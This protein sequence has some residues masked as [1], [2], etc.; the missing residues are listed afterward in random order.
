MSN[1]SFNDDFDD[2]RTAKPG[3]ST[4]VKVLIGVLVGGGLLSL[5]CCGGFMFF[6]WSV[7]KQVEL[8]T[9]PEEV[10]EIGGKI[11][12]IDI[13]AEYA[14][15]AGLKMELF[16]VV[17]AIA[18]YSDTDGDAGVVLMQVKMPEQQGQQEQANL[19]LDQQ[20][21]QIQ[22]MYRSQSLG[23]HYLPEPLTS[24][25]SEPRELTVRGEPVEFQFTKG[26]GSMSDQEMRQVEGTFSSDGGRIRIIVQ[27]PEEDYNEDDV[28]KMIESIQ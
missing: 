12:K 8:K 21:Q 22:E 7:A 24:S 3:M 18:S 23:Q 9:T 6:G 17:M 28:V 2:G 10:R 27:M 16:G 13:P 25:E 11:A 14:P 5:L 1:D 4:G 19:Q 15:Q 20:F 26:H